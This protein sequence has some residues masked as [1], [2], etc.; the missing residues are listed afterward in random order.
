MLNSLSFM[1]ERSWQN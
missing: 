1:T